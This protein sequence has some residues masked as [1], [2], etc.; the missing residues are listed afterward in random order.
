MSLEAAFKHEILHDA[1]AMSRCR[2]V[3]TKLGG[4]ARAMFLL[5]TGLGTITQDAHSRTAFNPELSPAMLQ[6]A[7]V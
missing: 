1:L 4:L 2:K 5:L 7:A 6:V 3:Q